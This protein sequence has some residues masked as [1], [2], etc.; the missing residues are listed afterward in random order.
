M[1]VCICIISILTFQFFHRSLSYSFKTPMSSFQPFNTTNST[2]SLF[3]QATH[4]LT[5]GLP[6]TNAKPPD[7]HFKSNATTRS[8]LIGLDVFNCIFEGLCCCLLLTIFKRSKKKKTPEL[9]VLNLAISEFFASVFLTARDVVNL[10][11]LLPQ[12]K[13]LGSVLIRSGS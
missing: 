4:N 5:Q 13:K 2:P 12:H 3:F 11:R 7:T 1:T 6:T 10:L 8:I 9:Y